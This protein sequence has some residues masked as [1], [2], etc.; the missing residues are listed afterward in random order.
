LQHI[1]DLPSEPM[2]KATEK[3]I[4]QFPTSRKPLNDFD[5]TQTLELPPKTT[6]HAKF[7]FDPATWV[8]WANTSLTL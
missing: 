3:G 5:E 7:D 4:F 6:S 8:V 2:A 1:C